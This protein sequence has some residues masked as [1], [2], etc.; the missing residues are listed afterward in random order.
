VLFRGEKKGEPAQGQNAKKKGRR[1]LS[2]KGKKRALAPEGNERHLGKKKEAD[3][4]RKSTVLPYLKKDTLEKR[5][6]PLYGGG[7]QEDEKGFSRRT[8]FHGRRKP[9]ASTEVSENTY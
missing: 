6:R 4:K 1:F 7:D 8:E 5:K 3:E 2:E 9:A